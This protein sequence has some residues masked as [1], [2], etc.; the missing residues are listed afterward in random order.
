MFVCSCSEATNSLTS[1]EELLVLIR[2]IV[3]LKPVDGHWKGVHDRRRP[4][5]IKVFSADLLLLFERFTNFL[6][7]VGLRVRGDRAHDL[8]S[9]GLTLILLETSSIEGRTTTEWTHDVRVW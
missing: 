5:L 3:L 9:E 7:P 6:L 8:L 2:V 4:L 1:L